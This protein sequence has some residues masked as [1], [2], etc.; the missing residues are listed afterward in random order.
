MARGTAQRLL[1]SAFVNASRPIQNGRD[2]PPADTGIAPRTIRIGGG[3][4]L[5]A[6]G[7]LRQRV[8]L[9]LLL[10]PG[11]LLQ[12]SAHQGIPV[13]DALVVELARAH[14]AADIGLLDGAGV[15]RRIS[16]ARSARIDAAVEL[17]RRQR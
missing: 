8:T 9:R 6:G 4:R 16:D 7:R 3:R 1:V 13:E 12:M 14:R 15:L 2:L 11:L 17:I 5:I 10:K